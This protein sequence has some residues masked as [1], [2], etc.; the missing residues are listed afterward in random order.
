MFK[1]RANCLLAIKTRSLEK[2]EE[3]ENDYYFT[4]IHVKRLA[5]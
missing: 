2:T 3:M 4:A 1:E 5:C